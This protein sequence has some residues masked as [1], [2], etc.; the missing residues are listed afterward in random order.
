[1]DGLSFLM[2]QKRNYIKSCW[3]HSLQRGEKPTNESLRE[4]LLTVHREHAGLTETCAQLCR[5]D[6]GRNTY[7]MLASLIDPKRDRAVL[8]LACGSGVLIE[9]CHRLYGGRIKLI[10]VDMSLDELSLARRRVPNKNVHLHQGLA[11]NLSFVKDASLDVALCHW[12]L[13]LMDPIAP[14]LD[15]LSRTIARGGVFGAI[16]DGDMTNAPDYAE[17]HRLIYDFVQ[18]EYPSY[19]AFELGDP[20]VRSSAE[21]I[22]LVETAFDGADIQVKPSLLKWK[23]SARVL[24]REVAG[25]FYA[26]YVLSSQLRIELMRELRAFFDAQSPGKQ[27]CFFMPVNMLLVRKPE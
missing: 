3:T 24:A 13:T 6:E 22:S 17:V 8:D 2:D 10:G 14:V 7:D 1:M 5:D 25:F 4:H 20:R 23:A 27:A 15:E 18:R 9:L 26:T 11:Q 12:A 19:A 16:T 21:L